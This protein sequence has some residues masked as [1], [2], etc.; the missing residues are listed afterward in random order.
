MQYAA[1][2]STSET[3]ADGTEVEENRQLTKLLLENSVSGDPGA[4]K[5]PRGT[6]VPQKTSI[7]EA[8]ILLTLA[9]LFWIYS[10]V[11]SNSMDE[12]DETY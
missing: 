6:I 4:S 10:L 12:F 5:S 8:A 9:P 1:R 2:R 11:V 7:L 3:G